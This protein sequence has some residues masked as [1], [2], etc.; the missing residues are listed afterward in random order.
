MLNTS[1]QQIPEGD[2]H[3]HHFDDPI[4]QLVDILK[5]STWIPQKF[6]VSRV[7]KS[8]KDNAVTNFMPEPIHIP[9]KDQKKATI[10][11]IPFFEPMPYPNSTSIH[12]P[13]VI[14]NIP[15][16]SFP[17]INVLNPM[18]KIPI[19]SFEPINFL[20]P[21]QPIPIPSFPPLGLGLDTEKKTCIWVLIHGISCNIIMT[22][23]YL[24]LFRLSPSSQILTSKLILYRGWQWTGFR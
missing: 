3:T 7:Q 24:T 15:L 6:V 21:V 18:H 12:I 10:I 22:D 17:P 14:P 5:S 13:N 20:Y 19:P 8:I 2:P 9:F 11:P 23:R 16:P 1:T 4:S